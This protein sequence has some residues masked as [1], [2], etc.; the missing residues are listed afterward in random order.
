MLKMSNKNW[1]TFR[2]P[3][4]SPILEV[5]NQNKGIAAHK[6]IENNMKEQPKTKEEKADNAFNDFINII[7][8][9]YPGNKRKIDT[10]RPIIFN[11]IL[12]IWNKEFNDKYE[13]LPDRYFDTLKES[14][15]DD[16]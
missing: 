15:N 4:D 10:L 7:E 1:K 13:E 14:L 9:L 6:A 3:L 8:E 12:K 16:L 11:K 5:I 2:V